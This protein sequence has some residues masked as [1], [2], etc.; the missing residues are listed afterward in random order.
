MGGLSIKVGILYHNLGEED[1][2]ITLRFDFSDYRALRL[3]LQVMVMM[4]HRRQIRVTSFDRVRSRARMV[5]IN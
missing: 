2:E 1:I 4:R 3:V 5:E